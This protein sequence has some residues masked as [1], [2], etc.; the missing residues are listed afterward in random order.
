M[1]SK[2]EEYNK[3]AALVRGAIGLTIESNPLVVKD[4]LADRP[5]CWGFLAG[6]AVMACR[7]NVGRTLTDHERRMVWQELWESLTKLRNSSIRLA[8]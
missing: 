1:V 2:E 3:L 4:W 8:E 5:G 6:Q 7:E